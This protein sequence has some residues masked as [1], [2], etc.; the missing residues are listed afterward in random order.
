M[1]GGR[2]GYRE[3]HYMYVCVWLDREGVGWERREGMGYARILM[4]SNAW[5]YISVCMR[6]NEREGVRERERDVDEADGRGGKRTS[7]RG[8]E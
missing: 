4:A 8:V 6:A 3:R 5:M 1:S 2:E 7:L